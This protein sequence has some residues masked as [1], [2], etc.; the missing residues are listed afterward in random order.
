FVNEIKLLQRDKVGHNFMIYIAKILLLI[1]QKNE[2]R[3]SEI[4]DGFKMYFKRYIK[5]GFFKRHSVFGNYII[6]KFSKDKNRVNHDKFI[7]ILNETSNLE[8]TEIVPYEVLIK[9]IEN[10]DEGWYQ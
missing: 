4:E 2:K 5:N 6:E 1:K 7:N 10:L 3:L 8:E 9:L